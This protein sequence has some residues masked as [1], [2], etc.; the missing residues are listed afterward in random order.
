[1]EN[2][3]PSRHFQTTFSPLKLHKFRSF[4]RWCRRVDFSNGHFSF[5]PF[6]VDWIQRLRF[7][8]QNSIDCFDAWTTPF[9]SFKWLDWLDIYGVISNIYLVWSWWIN[10]IELIQLNW[11]KKAGDFRWFSLIVVNQFNWINHCTWFIST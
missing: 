11:I 7:E 2:L 3:R 9:H 4:D 6:I 8:W 5:G 1:M 10:W